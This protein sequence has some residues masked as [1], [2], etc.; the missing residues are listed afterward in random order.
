MLLSMGIIAWCDLSCKVK[1]GQLIK[2]QNLYTQRVQWVYEGEH[3]YIQYF[4]NPTS[5]IS[6]D[7]IHLP[8]SISGAC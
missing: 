8:V 2:I 6:L 1:V 7:P 5:I 4:A 3:S